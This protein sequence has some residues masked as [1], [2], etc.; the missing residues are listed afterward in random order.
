MIRVSEMVLP[1]H[2][3]KFCDQ[4]ADAVVA[5]CYAVALEGY[6]QVEVS[7]WSDQVWLS[8]GTATRAPLRRPLASIAF[9]SVWNNRAWIYTSVNAGAVV[10]ITTGHTA[11][12]SCVFVLRKYFCS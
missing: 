1:G 3:D 2:P 10:T 11:A 5:E 7:V 6:C 8:G 4:V 12:S 9:V